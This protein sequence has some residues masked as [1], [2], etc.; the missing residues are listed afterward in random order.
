MQCAM[1]VVQYPLT[2]D[3]QFYHTRLKIHPVHLENFHFAFLLP[4][5]VS[6]SDFLLSEHCHF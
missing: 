4:A 1:V 6:H 3:R 5:V 2:A